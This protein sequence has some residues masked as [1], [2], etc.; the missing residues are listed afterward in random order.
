MS[1]TN[2]QWKNTTV[3]PM[4]KLRVKFV[5]GD[6]LLTLKRPPPNTLPCVNVNGLNLFR[7]LSSGCILALFQALLLEQKIV[8]ISTSPLLLLQ[9]AETI[10]TLIFPFQYQGVYMPILPQS[11]LDFL[12]S[13]VPFLAGVQPQWLDNTPLDEVH[14]YVVLVYLDENRV[15]GPPD[16][17]PLPMRAMEKLERVLSSLPWLNRSPERKGRIRHRKRLKLGKMG[18]GMNNSV[19]SIVVNDEHELELTN[20]IS[21]TNEFNNDS[22]TNNGNIKDNNGNAYSMDGSNNSINNNNNNSDVNNNNTNT[23][24]GN[25]NSNN[26][27]NN[28]NNS[29]NNNSINNNNNVSGKYANVSKKIEICLPELLPISRFLMSGTR[30]E[31]DYKSSADGIDT[32]EEELF[33]RIQ[34]GFLKFFTSILQ[35]YHKYFEEKN[36]KPKCQYEFNRKHFLDETT[37]KSSRPFM[38]C[39]TNTQMFHSF[40]QERS[41]YMEEQKQNG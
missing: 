18:N 37:D 4:G 6:V 27:N 28:N 8:F 7:C 3:P 13:P 22:N 23:N 5:I 1:N 25:N 21:N 10:T 12:S 34:H 11:L 9:A 32:L 36:I 20:T 16:L 33:R 14:V 29:G 24:N 40:V 15:M 35:E 41:E 19:S 30:V 39:F 26:N 2:E 38:E 17:P 31:S